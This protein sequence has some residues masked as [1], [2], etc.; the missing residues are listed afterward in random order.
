MPLALLWC[1]VDL[2]R[3]VIQVT[4]TIICVNGQS[5]IRKGAKSAAGHRPLVLPDWTLEI[6]RRRNAAGVGPYE[7]VFSTMDGG[8]RDPRNVS[9]WICA[10]GEKSGLDWVTTHS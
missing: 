5:L 2:D 3:G 6:L 1:E 8:F 9:R 7:P 4:S 10:A